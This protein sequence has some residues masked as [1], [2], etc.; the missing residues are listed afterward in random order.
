MQGPV[1]FFIESVKAGSGGVIVKF[2]WIDSI[3]ASEK[4]M[5][6]EVLIQAD[7][8]AYTEKS[9]IIG[10]NLIDLISGRSGEVVDV[11]PLHHHPLLV[12]DFDGKET[13]IPFVEDYI[14]EV[15]DDDRIIR[16]N[17]PNG[18]LDL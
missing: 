18:L 9:P 3:E 12:V 2:E 13:M 15:H 17:L 6:N 5:G 14:E 7:E 16:M 8:E 1:P 4:L 10:F 11:R